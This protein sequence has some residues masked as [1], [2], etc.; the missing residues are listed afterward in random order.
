MAKRR[1]HGEGTLYYSNT[2][3]LWVAQITLPN[4]KRKTKYSKDQK[5]AREWLLAQRDALKDGFLVEDDKLT[6]SQFL[7]KWYS[8]VAV[9]S[10]RPKSLESYEYLIRLHI[11]PNIGFIKLVNLSPANLQNLYSKKINQ[12]LSNRTVQYIHSIIH[13][14]L[15]QALRWGWVSRNV[16][17]LVQPPSIKRKSPETLNSEQVRKLLAVLL[18]DRLYP[19]YV[20]AISTGMREGEL[21]GLYWEDVDFFSNTIHVRRAIQ[22]LRNKGLV[23]TEPKSD[24]SKRN[25]A[26][27]TFAM[28]VLWNYKEAQGYTEGLVFRTANN[29]PISPRNLVR[30]F[31][32]SLQRAELPNIRFHDL[33]H[34]AATLLLNS[35]VHPKVVQE[36]LGHSQINLTLDTYSHVLPD[37]QRE[38]A[39]KMDLLLRN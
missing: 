13:R 10:L 19:L 36:M 28:D 3:E 39:E 5:T 8:D 37:I 20:L 27:P 7:D 21:L 17:D 33:R 1:S 35:G 16:A 12:G 26:V 32:S 22:Q 24:K 15:N 38:A 18:G 23:I 14:A 25:I 31:K 11:K 29:T 30:H 34:T 4:N 2:H 9:H 6:V